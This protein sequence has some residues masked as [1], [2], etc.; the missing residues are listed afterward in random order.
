[1]RRLARLSYL[2]CASTL[3]SLTKIREQTRDA[4]N[5][6]GAVPKLPCWTDARSASSIAVDCFHIAHW[7]QAGRRNNSTNCSQDWNCDRPTSPS[8]LSGA[9][10]GR[11]TLAWE[12]F[13]TE[14]LVMLL[15]QLRDGN[16]DAH[17]DQHDNREKIV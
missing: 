9:P 6:N 2:R 10:I 11:A 1:V 4:W 12:P 5:I 17:R 14:F 8:L 3:L 13:P 15:R 7:L 16:H